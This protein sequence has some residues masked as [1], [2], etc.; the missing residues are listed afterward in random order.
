MKQKIQKK[1]QK[2]YSSLIRIT[3]ILSDLNLPIRLKLS[4]YKNNYFLY[5]KIYFYVFK[6]KKKI[7][8]KP[9]YIYLN[10]I[11]KVMIKEIEN[12]DNINKVVYFISNDEDLRKI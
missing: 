9:R 4:G 1:K 11:G 8:D 7:S 12:L 10:E 6:D 5:K 2:I 3:K